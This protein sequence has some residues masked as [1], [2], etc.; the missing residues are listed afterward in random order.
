ML[1]N[2]EVCKKCLGALHKGLFSRS[3]DVRKKWSRAFDEDWKQGWITCAAA[4]IMKPNVMVDGR[5]PGTC[6][7]IVEHVVSQDAE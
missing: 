5:P 4:P 6:P 3:E 2:K 7:Y 1:L